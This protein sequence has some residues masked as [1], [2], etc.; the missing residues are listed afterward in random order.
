MVGVEQK[1]KTTKDAIDVIGTVTEDFSKLTKKDLEKAPIAHISDEVVDF[2]T[3]GAHTGVVRR[4]F[5]VTNMGRST[6]HIRR[7]YCGDKSVGVAIDAKEVK[8]GA[9]CKVSVA[10]NAAE[11]SDAYLNAKLTV[12]TNDPAHSWQ[13]V[14]LV[15][16]KEK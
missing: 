14:R 16:I 3:I 13:E 11:I 1:G 10:V 9:N 7:V 8:P 5:T 4:E 15:G 6:L 2:G 12:I